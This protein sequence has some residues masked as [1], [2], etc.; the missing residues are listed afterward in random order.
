VAWSRLLRASAMINA[1]GSSTSWPCQDDVDIPRA[2]MPGICL[3]CGCTRGGE[4]LLPASAP[5]APPPPPPRP[6][7]EVDPAT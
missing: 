7:L 5:Q 4:M 6:S 3:V 2:V 1:S